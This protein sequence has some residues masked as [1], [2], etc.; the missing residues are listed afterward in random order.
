VDSYCRN[1]FKNGVLPDSDKHSLERIIPDLLFRYMYEFRSKLQRWGVVDI[2]R[3]LVETYADRILAHLKTCR[4]RQAEAE[5]RCIFEKENAAQEKAEGKAVE[6]A[7]RK[8][9]EM[10]IKTETRVKN[11][12]IACFSPYP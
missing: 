3:N 2:S 6:E 9:A 12:V 10:T 8:A 5:G 7:L 1:T 11:E 4:S